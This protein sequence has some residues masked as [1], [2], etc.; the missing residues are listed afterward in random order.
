MT[1]KETTGKTM[2]NHWF[3]HVAKTR[4]KLSRGKKEGMTHRVA[5]TEASQT[6]P[7][8]KKKLL[9]KI[10]RA[11]KKLKSDGVVKL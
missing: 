5:M 4:K 6:W 1:I 10:S 8:V 9:N 3:E 2:R 11:Q 7:A